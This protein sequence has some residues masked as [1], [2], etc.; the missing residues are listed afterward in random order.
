MEK[1]NEWIRKYPG[2][3]FL[4]ILCLTFLIILCLMALSAVGLCV[5]PGITLVAGAALIGAICAWYMI[6]LMVDDRWDW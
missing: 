2:I 5:A 6:M 1:Y 4:I 3:T